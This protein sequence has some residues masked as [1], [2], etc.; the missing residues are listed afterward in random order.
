M[1]HSDI[2]KL[3][4]RLVSHSLHY[5]SILKNLNSFLFFKSWVSY[6]SIYTSLVSK[7]KKK[8]T[9]NELSKLLYLN[10]SP[11][12]WLIEYPHRHQ[13][14][15]SLPHSF[16]CIELTGIPDLFVITCTKKNHKNENVKV[17][18]ARCCSGLDPVCQLGLHL[19]CEPFLS[20]RI[21]L[22]IYGLL[23]SCLP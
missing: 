12:S 18:V 7:R 22:D 16:P 13:S 2:T 23:S 8:F 9:C 20:L 15:T 4:K 10:F 14:S 6:V 19:Y 3:A 21:G 5:Y 11:N 1:K 17:I